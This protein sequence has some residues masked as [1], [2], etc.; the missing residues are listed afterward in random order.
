MQSN[1]L[2][3]LNKAED[4][5]LEQDASIGSDSNEND[6]QI[7]CNYKDTS[8]SSESLDSVDKNSL[9]AKVPQSEVVTPTFNKINQDWQNSSQMPIQCIKIALDALNTSIAYNFTTMVPEE[10]SDDF[11]IIVIP[12]DKT[13]TEVR[14]SKWQALFQTSFYDMIS[15]FYSK[16]I[17]HNMYEEAH[18][19]L[20]LVHSLS[21]IRPNF[22]QPSLR[23]QLH[24][25]LQ[26]FWSRLMETKEGL[27]NIDIMLKFWQILSTFHKLIS[28][29]DINRADKWLDEVHDFTVNV[30]K[31]GSEDESRSFGCVHFLLKFWMNLTFKW[32][33]LK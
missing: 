5:N 9:Y 32:I 2:Q 27:E 24:G 12:R 29:Y 8:E 17:E 14:L 18:G 11:N 30:F 10:A 20:S 19:V 33:S 16:L 26:T 3:Q 7:N 22:P 25:F 21:L 4:T 23:Q 28:L 31:L 13:I 15:M 6:E 1:D